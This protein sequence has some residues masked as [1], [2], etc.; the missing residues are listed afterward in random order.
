MRFIFR[1]KPILSHIK[2]IVC[3]MY[4]CLSVFPYVLFFQ[5]SFL[6][7]LLNNSKYSF[8]F[9]CLPKYSIFFISEKLRICLSR[10]YGSLVTEF[11]IEKRKD[12]NKYFCPLNPFSHCLSFSQ[13][14]YWFLII[15]LIPQGAVDY[16]LGPHRLAGTKALDPNYCRQPTLWLHELCLEVLTKLVLSCGCLGPRYS[17]CSCY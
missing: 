2:R 3:T 17:L 6:T 10:K 11:L 5:Y 12:V 13:N 14:L 7:I 1:I 8:K 9:N 16:N 15:R 4:N